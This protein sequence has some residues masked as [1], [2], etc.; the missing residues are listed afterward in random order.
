MKYI[1]TF[2]SIYKYEVGDM[3]YA[4]LRLPSFKHH[5]GKILKIDG[6]NVL[7]EFGEGLRAT[8]RWCN[9]DNIKN[10]ITKK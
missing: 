10:K 9:I 6:R 4:D 2:E 8:E 3:V 1:K 7:I 5:V